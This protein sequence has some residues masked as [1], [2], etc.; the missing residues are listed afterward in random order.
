MS[1]STRN[2][3]LGTKFDLYRDIPTLK[4]YIVIDSERIGVTAFRINMNNQWVLKDYK[5]FQDTVL[6]PTVEV[7]L[8]M[9]D[10]YNGV[11]FT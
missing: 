10:I 2:Y 6:I 1:K 8:S 3:D 5:T 11:V 7:T 4:E 9:Q